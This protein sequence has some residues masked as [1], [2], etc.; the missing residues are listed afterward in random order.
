MSKTR[1]FTASR[2]FWCAWKGALADG[3]KLNA[4]PARGI[5][6]RNLKKC[7]PLAVP[8]PADRE[9]RPVITL[10]RPKS[11]ASFQSQGIVVSDDSE[12]VNRSMK[13]KTKKERLAL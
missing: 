2:F 5:C 4:H 6:Q 9:I 8:R 3:L 12:P 11:I 1:G 10:F 7:L 13:R